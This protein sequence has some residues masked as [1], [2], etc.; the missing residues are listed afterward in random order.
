M[1][2]D[3]PVNEE[4]TIDLGTGFDM[5]VAVGGSTSF[6]RTG[7]TL[8]LDSNDLV[9]NTGSGAQALTSILQKMN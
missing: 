6:K 8:D 3:G 7:L 5:I 9:G 1:T 4:L 2:V